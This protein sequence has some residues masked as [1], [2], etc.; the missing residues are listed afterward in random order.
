MFYPEDLVDDPSIFLRR[1]PSGTDPFTTNGRDVS[2]CRSSWRRAPETR[3]ASFI[4]ASCPKS[5]AGVSGGL[6][7]LVRTSLRARSARAKSARVCVN[8]LEAS[9]SVRTINHKHRYDIQ[10]PK[11]DQIHTYRGIVG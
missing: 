5:V 1:I 11:L 4:S 8:P 10:P 3:R 2:R 9:A 6:P 7:L